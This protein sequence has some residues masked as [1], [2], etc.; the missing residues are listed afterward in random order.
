MRGERSMMA[1]SSQ[2]VYLNESARVKNHRRAKI[3][4]YE[5]AYTED[6]KRLSIVWNQVRG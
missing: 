4:F 5:A 2:S 6:G 3:T 1:D